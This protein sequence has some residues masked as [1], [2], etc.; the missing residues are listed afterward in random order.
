MEMLSEAAVGQ[1][2]RQ[3]RA[4]QARSEYPVLERTI[5]PMMQEF[6]LNQVRRATSPEEMFEAKGA[7]KLLGMMQNTLRQMSQDSK[8]KVG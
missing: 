7:L 6:I 3:E 5:I 4:S 1:I 8:V 2:L